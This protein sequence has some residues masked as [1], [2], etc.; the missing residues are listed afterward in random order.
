MPAVNPVIKKFVFGLTTL[1]SVWKG[2]LTRRLHSTL[3]PESMN[4]ASVLTLPQTCSDQAH[5][6]PVAADSWV[7]VPHLRTLLL[8]F[9]STETFILW[10]GEAV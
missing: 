9:G 7:P 8:I 10:H 4:R 3:Q 1:I 6:G 5:R 2:A